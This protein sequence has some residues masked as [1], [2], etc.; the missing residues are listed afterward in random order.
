ML[1]AAV[2]VKRLPSDRAGFGL[3]RLAPIEVRA[4]WRDT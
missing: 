1:P 3:A 4:E 2:L